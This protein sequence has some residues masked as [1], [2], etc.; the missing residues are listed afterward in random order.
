MKKKAVVDTTMSARGIIAI[1]RADMDI[2]SAAVLPKTS[3]LV[4]TVCRVR[5]DNDCPPLPNDLNELL[6]PDKYTK[7]KGEQFLMFDSGPS[8]DRI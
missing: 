7:S 5:N 4:L 8:N 6:L 1:A 2:A 3:S